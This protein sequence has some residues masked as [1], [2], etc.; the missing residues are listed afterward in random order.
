MKGPVGRALTFCRNVF[1]RE[2]EKKSKSGRQRFRIEPLETRLL[3]SVD[4]IGIPGWIPDGP[5][6]IL[7]AP[8]VSAAPG[9]A[10]GGAVQS[11]AINPNNAQQIYIGTVNG[12]MPT[13][14]IPTMSRGRR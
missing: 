8:S 10:A 14:R 1:S 4:L 12:G 6:P 5:Q 2:L 9:D 13:R 3:L 7:D 11:I